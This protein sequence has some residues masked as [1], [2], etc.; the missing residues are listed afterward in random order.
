MLSLFQDC[1]LIHENKNKSWAIKPEMLNRNFLV[2]PFNFLTFQYFFWYFK[3]SNIPRCQSSGNFAQ[4]V[5]H[6]S[7][8][9]I[10]FSGYFYW[11]QDFWTILTGISK[12]INWNYNIF[13]V[14]ILSFLTLPLSVMMSCLSIPWAPP[15][16]AFPAPAPLVR[17]AGDRCRLIRYRGHAYRHYSVHQ[18]WWDC[19]DVVHWFDDDALSKDGGW[20]LQNLKSGRREKQL[21]N[22]FG[23]T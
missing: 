16:W 2:I 18:S 1:N 15:L 12:Y 20:G 10:K 11:F 8:G 5:V 19:W 14:C 4:K 6:N 7:I 23:T 3:N 13:D 9:I 22:F 17:Y 21:F